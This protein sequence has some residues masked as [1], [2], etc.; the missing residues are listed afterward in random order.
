MTFVQF[1]A[2]DRIRLVSV[3]V[4]AFGIV[5]AGEAIAQQGTKSRHRPARRPSPGPIQRAIASTSSTYPSAA[6]VAR[7][8]T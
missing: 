1:L 4:A 5:F 6:T 7:S 3:T 2:H 8:N